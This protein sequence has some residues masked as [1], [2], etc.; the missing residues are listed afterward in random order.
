MWLLAGGLSPSIGPLHKAIGDV[1]TAFLQKDLSKSESSQDRSCSVFYDGILDMTHHYF[2]CI[3]SVISPTLLQHGRDY[4][5][6]EHQ[7][8][9]DNGRSTS[10]LATTRF[11]FQK[12]G[13]LS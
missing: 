1:A 3:L 12:G 10:R 4:T 13:S 2:C 6:C 5:E 8:T 7:E 11:V 9:G